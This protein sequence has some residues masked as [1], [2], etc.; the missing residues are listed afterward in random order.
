MS[1]T[2]LPLLDPLVKANAKRTYS[3]FASCP[4]A[5]IREEEKSARLRLAVKINDEYKHYKQLPSALL[6]QQAPVGPARPKD[7]RK[8]ITAGRTSFV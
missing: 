4:D 3:V 7:Q 5:G 2:G 1:V 8:M 6:E